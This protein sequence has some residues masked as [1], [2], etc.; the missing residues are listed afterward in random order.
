MNKHAI[1]VIVA[2]IAIVGTLGFSLWNVSAA[3]QIQIR[4]VEDDGYFSFFNLVN[5]KKVVMCNPYPIPVN[6]KEVRISMEY[7]GEDVG[8]IH[9]PQVFLEPNATSTLQG[10]LISDNFK[11][12]QYLGLHFDGIHNGAIP[13]RININHMNIVVEYDTP[14]FGVIPYTVTEEYPNLSFWNFMNNQNTKYTC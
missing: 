9:F 2:I 6:L 7:T 1:I 11:Q 5:N 14:I 10:K 4:G 13:S 3:E 12:M 8:R